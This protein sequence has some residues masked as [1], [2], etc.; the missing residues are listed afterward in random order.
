VCVSSTYETGKEKPSSSVVPA[1]PASP[2]IFMVRICGKA[3]T[4]WVREDYD[5]VFIVYVRDG[6]IACCWGWGVQGESDVA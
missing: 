1:G 3:P 6:D 5:A 2:V 4:V